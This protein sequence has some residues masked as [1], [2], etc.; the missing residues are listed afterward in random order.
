MAICAM[1]RDE[2]DHDVVQL[3]ITMSNEVEWAMAIAWRIQS[4]MAAARA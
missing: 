4:T 3:A 1:G 2:R